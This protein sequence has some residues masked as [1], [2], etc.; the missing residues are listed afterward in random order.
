MLWTTDS[1][2]KKQIVYVVCIKHFYCIQ[3]L[4]AVQSQLIKMPCF[5]WTFPALQGPRILLTSWPTTAAKSR[6][7]EPQHF[8]TASLH[9]LLFPCENQPSP[10]TSHWL[11]SCAEPPRGWPDG[12]LLLPETS[13]LS[14]EFLWSSDPLAQAEIMVFKAHD[15]VPRHL[16][17]TCLAI[18][19][20][21]G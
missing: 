6:L 18:I 9:T 21:P 14:K 20:T 1:F 7:K 8:H 4:E 10:E 11:L 16:K 13:E 3:V 5:L 17:I 12:Q 2:Q 19:H 15:K